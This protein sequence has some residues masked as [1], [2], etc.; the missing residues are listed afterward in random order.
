[1][2]SFARRRDANERPVVAA[3]VAAGCAVQRLDAPGVPDLLVSFRDRLYLLEVKNPEAKGGGKYNTG[4][5]WLTE[6]QVEWRER[7]KG[8]QP[9]DVVSAEE[10]LRAIGAIA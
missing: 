9:I 8:V 2:A 1:M 7:W 10:A 4:G 3:L 5:R 6:Q